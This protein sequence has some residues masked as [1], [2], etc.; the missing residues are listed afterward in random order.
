ML[1]RTMGLMAI[2]IMAALIMGCGTQ[3]EPALQLGHMDSTIKPGDDFFHY[4]NGSY[5]KELKIPEDKTVYNVF[6]ILRENRDRDINALLKEIAASHAED[7]TVDQKI[8]DFYNTAMDV[9]AIE[10]AGAQPLKADLDAI[11]ALD[12]KDAMMDLVADM[13]MRGMD[14]FFGGGVMQNLANSSEYAFYMAQAGVGLP[15]VEYYTKKDKRTVEI[16]DGYVKH[17]AHMFELLGDDAETA[18]A[19]AR[20]V[21]GIEATLAKASK[22]GK[23]MRNIRGMYNPRTLKQLQ[24]MTRVID[25][26]RYFEAIGGM[27]N[28]SVIV[29]SPKFYETLGK[30]IKKTCLC[31]MKTYLRWNLVNRNAESLSDDFVK[32]DWDFYSAFLSGAQAQ[33][34][35]WKRV[36]QT[37]SA[38]LDE[39]LGQ[40]YVRKHFPPESKARMVDLVANLRKALKQRIE[41]VAWM[42]DETKA[43]ALA[44]LETM[45]VKIGYPDKWKDYTPL[46]IT[47]DGYAQNIWRV[48][49][50]SH[51]DNLDKLGKPV[52][53]AEWGM[54]PQTVNAGYNPVLNDITFPAGILQP[55]YFNPDA[56]DAVN[57]GA[58][59]VVIGHEMTHG[60]DD[61]GRRFDKDGNMRDWWTEEDAAEFDKRTKILVDQY[62]Q[63][64]AVDDVHID[65][66]LTLGENIADFG[67]L[68]ISL[69]AYN[70][71]KAGQNVAPIDGF[72]DLQRF[73][74]S[75]GAIWSGKIR[76]KALI[77]K[78]QEDVHPWGEFRVNGAPFNVPEFY[79]AFDIAP[80]DKLYIAPEA[81]PVIW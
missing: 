57:Y 78:C 52:D 72:T 9:E 13:H 27:N 39:P 33:E 79:T 37:V 47:T 46:Q 64:V 6:N 32:A 65:G 66:E 3:P 29:I 74:L 61:Q 80:E 77:R 68:T 55:P 62:N 20:T 41:N 15:D 67:G 70:M 76:E 25:W 12:S 23:E 81:R 50:F 43:Q 63:F 45:N 36:T 19:N 44:K 16:R 4:V 58:I 10:A 53:A 35:R 69:T 51:K 31:D 24:K 38:M 73:F 14:P 54:S 30:V 2:L 75:Y 48:R 40:L 7:G 26:K 56:D 5:L 28:E 17:M 49:R 18:H 60:F 42:G 59:G 21:M 71:A 1:K 11:E 34:A 8:R 22:T